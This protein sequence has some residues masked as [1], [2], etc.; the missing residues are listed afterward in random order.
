MF[1][2]ALTA[3]PAWDAGVVADVL[4]RAQR[5]MAALTSADLVDWA[6]TRLESPTRTLDADR[7][8]HAALALAHRTA[9]T[10]DE[11]LVPDPS[12]PDVRRRHRLPATGEGYR[13]PVFPGAAVRGAFVFYGA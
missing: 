13:R 2:E 4:S 12:T 8:S 6:C 9:G 5:R 11:D 1:H 7:L 3:E 10:P